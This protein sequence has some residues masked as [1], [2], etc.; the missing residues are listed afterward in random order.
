MKDLL[1]CCCEEFG[2]QLVQINLNPLFPCFA[3]QSCCFMC[4]YCDHFA[5]FI[6]SC[7]CHHLALIS[8][9]VLDVVV[10]IVWEEALVSK[11]DNDSIKIKSKPHFLFALLNRNVAPSSIVEHHN[12][13]HLSK[14][15]ELLFHAI[16][17]DF[18]HCTLVE[19]IGLYDNANFD[20]GKEVLENEHVIKP[21]KRRKK[22]E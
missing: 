4:C 11:M 19:K 18:S 7:H 15:D 3:F 13:K 16:L 21:R 5:L 12:T 14:L 1:L 17:Y 20:K 6:V 2:W 10:N 8:F 22:I 9:C